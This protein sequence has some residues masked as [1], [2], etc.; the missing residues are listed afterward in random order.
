MFFFVLR[1]VC[2][3]ASPFFY[4]L[5]W[6]FFCSHVFPFS[7]MAVSFFYMAF[8]CS[9]FLTNFWHVLSIILLSFSLS[10]ERHCSCLLFFVFHMVN[11]RNS[12]RTFSLFEML[13]HLFFCMLFFSF[14]LYFFCIILAIFFSFYMNFCLLH[15]YHC[16]TN[17]QSRQ[18]CQALWC[19]M[20]G[21]AFGIFMGKRG[22]T[23]KGEITDSVAR[24]WA[25]SFEPGSLVKLHFWPA[26]LQQSSHCLWANVTL[27]K[28]LGNEREWPIYPEQLNMPAAKPQCTDILTADRV[29]KPVPLEHQGREPNSAVR[30][31]V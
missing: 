1:S 11:V 2:F 26:M 12:I 18:F 9:F 17:K 27:P 10:L 20:K 19:T 13:F 5:A 4:F 6:P 29:H 8:L 31:C 28:T 16:Q 24:M 23:V 15:F 22:C 30:H 14:F 25:G 7:C 3:L 21:G